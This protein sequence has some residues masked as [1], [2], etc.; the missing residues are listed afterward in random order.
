LF[1]QEML[2][3]E[4]PTVMISSIQES[5]VRRPAVSY[6]WGL[7]AAKAHLAALGAPEP[8]LLPYDESKYEPMPEVEIDPLDDPE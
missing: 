4:R 5:L 3:A 2:M 7:E 1:Q 8:Q 6:H